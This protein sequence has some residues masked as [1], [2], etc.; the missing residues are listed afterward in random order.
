MD[1]LF[2]EEGFGT[3][4]QKS[5]EST[6][7]VLT[8]LTSANKLVGVIS[9]RQEL[10]AGIPQQIHVEKTPTGSTFKVDRGI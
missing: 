6:L 5:I 4:D 3:L 8:R 1:A 2:V 9:H 10:I 7:E